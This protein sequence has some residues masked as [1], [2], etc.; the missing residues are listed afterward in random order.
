MKNIEYLVGTPEISRQPLPPYSDEAIEFASQLS[1]NIMRSPSVRI[2]PDMSAL[3]FWCRKANLQKMKANCPEADKR[4]G[5]GL[6]FHVAPGNIPV[7][8]AFSYLFGLMSGCSNIVRLSSKPYPQIAPICQTVAETLRDFPEIEKRT[9]F[10]RY[11]ADDETTAAFSKDADARLIWGGDRTIATVRAMASKPRCVDVCFADRYSIC[12]IDG[13]QILAAD[14]E[15]LARLAENFYNDTYLMDQNACSSEQ[16]ILWLR[17]SEEARERFWAAVYAL[18]VQKYELQAELGVD[19]Y[20]HMFED[21]LDGR[22]ISSFRRSGNLLYR[23][24]L[25]ELRGELTVLRGKGG[26]FY[27][28]GISSLDELVP[29]VSDKFQTVTYF[30]TDPEAVR[31][32][33]IRNRLR[34]IDRIV[35][36]GKAMDIDILWDGYDLVRVLSRYVDVR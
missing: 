2:Y 17:D 5:R 15:T 20:T 6:C 11:P 35:P 25:D 30:G 18:A 4:L 27:E 23:A 26:Y 29:F 28:Y 19:K 12:I 9:A 22:P 36:V 24:Q 3:A 31:S 7:N 13:E 16:L 21:I 34:G 10:V 14:G 1:K 32:F 33:V 8:F